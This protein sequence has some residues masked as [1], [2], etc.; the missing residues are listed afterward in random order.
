MRTLVGQSS[1][2][3]YIDT[4]LQRNLEI[5]TK[6]AFIL[7]PNKITLPIFKQKHHLLVDLYTDKR[8]AR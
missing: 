3:I 5:D 8:D 2:P 1:I 4:C 7:I 6:K